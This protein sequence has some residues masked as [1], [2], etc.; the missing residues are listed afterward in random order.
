MIKFYRFHNS[1]NASI[2]VLL[3][4]FT[5]LKIQAPNFIES[6]SMVHRHH[7]YNNI[8]CKI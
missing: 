4:Y 2:K 5:L 6:R 3:Y 1:I 8:T 7:M